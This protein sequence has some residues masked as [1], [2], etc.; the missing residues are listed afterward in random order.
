MD[1][2]RGDSHTATRCG[3]ALSHR[4]VYIHVGVRGE[5]DLPGTEFVRQILWLS[6]MVWSVSGVFEL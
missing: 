4:A 2:L 1:N 3:L 6:M 5:R